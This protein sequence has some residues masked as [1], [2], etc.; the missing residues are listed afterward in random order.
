MFR[1]K[2]FWIILLFTATVALGNLL[3]EHNDYPMQVRIAWEGF[4][5]SRNA[6]IQ[7]DT[8]L[9][10]TVN[11]NGFLA[12]G[13]YYQLKNQ[14]YVIHT[15]GDTVVSVNKMMLDKMM[16]ELHFAGIQRAERATDHLTLKI[17]PRA[18]KAF[19][20][21]MRNVEFQFD[22]QHGLSGEPSLTPDTVWLYGSESSLA[23]IESLYT[24]PATIGGVSDT[25][26]C[27]L[28]LEPVWEKYPDL[29]VSSPNVTLVIPTKRYTEK[30]LS[31]PV[32]FLP[33][34]EVEGIPRL[35]PDHV[36]VTFWVADE[37]YSRLLADMVEAVAV[38][39]PAQEYGQGRPHSD[40]A[41]TLPVRITSFPSFARVKSVSP[42][43]IQ[44][45]IIRS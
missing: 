20:P 18:S 2:P 39:D 13:R 26:T 10:V 6:V 29:R 15:Q 44:Y 43:N 41:T 33:V 12:I 19:R 8:L 45:V 34:K 38:Y 23:K 24:A 42:S 27:I 5:T 1:H 40:K 11:S 25:V 4:D 21:Q 22:S 36:D 35:Y 9:E 14:K 3:S 30:K 32:R 7:A 17:S 16:Q 28:P 31:V 37:D